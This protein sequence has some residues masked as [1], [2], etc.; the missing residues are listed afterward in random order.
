M[1]SKIATIAW[2]NE[3]FQMN[4]EWWLGKM[5]YSSRLKDIGRTRM[6]RVDTWSSLVRQSVPRPW[7]CERERS[8]HFRF[9][10]FLHAAELYEQSCIYESV[11]VARCCP[12]AV[13]M[14]RRWT[15]GVC[16]CLS[17]SAP[18]WLRLH[19]AADTAMLGVVMLY[20]G[21]HLATHV[22][23]RQTAR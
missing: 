17:P 2:W 22:T 1:V 18:I 5:F 16:V 4:T 11:S 12:G 23:W 7:T 3:D 8:Y 9:A 21:T 6:S 19:C 13:V 14:K 15:D 20:R 10:Y